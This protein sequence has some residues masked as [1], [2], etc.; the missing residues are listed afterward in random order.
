MTQVPILTI[1]GPSGAGKGTVALRL[2]AMTGWQLLDSGALYRLT[3][4]AAHQQGLSLDDESALAHLA[5]HLPVRF[6]LGAQGAEPFLQD[7]SVSHLIRTEEVAAMASNVAKLPGVRQGLLA[8]QRA[9]AQPPGLVADGRD[10]GTVVFPEAD[11]KVFLTASAQERANRRVLQLQAA[12]KEAD[13]QQIHQQVVER[14]HQDSTRAAAPLKPAADA[15]LIDSTDL[16][17]DQ[18]VAQIWQALCAKKM[19]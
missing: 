12:G 15:L 4:L 19:Q 6:E 18:V 11:L 13:W 17:I 8:R 14:D 5:E 1:D 3:A 9:F 10:M 16:S 7:Q 2:A